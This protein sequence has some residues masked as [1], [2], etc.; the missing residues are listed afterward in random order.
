MADPTPSPDSPKPVSE[1]SIAGEEDPGAASDIQP[2]G[3]G[4]EVGP[5]SVQTGKA[6]C[7][8]CAGSG[9]TEHDEVCPKCGGLGTIMVETPGA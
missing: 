8:R 6:P 5:G 1:E 3:H 9:R 2:A 4:E 7:P